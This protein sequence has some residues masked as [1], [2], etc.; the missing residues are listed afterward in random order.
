MA[1]FQ[2]LIKNFDRIRNYMRDFYIYGFKVRNDYKYKSSRTYD[3]ERRRIESWIGDYIIWKHDARGKSVSI[4][5][6]SK[7]VCSNPL[8]AIWKSKSFTDNDIILHFLLL[9]ILQKHTYSADEITDKLSKDYGIIFDM[10]TVR[11]KLNEYVKSGILFSEKSGKK[12]L[13]SLKEQTL[14]NLYCF[15]DIL[16]SI[17]YYQETMP[18]GFVGNTILDQM[19]VRNTIFRFKHYFMVHTLEDIILLQILKCIKEKRFISFENFSRKSNRTMQ[20]YGVPMKIQVSTQT[21]R[22]Y[23]TLYY[24]KNRRFGNARLDY[25][26]SVQSGNIV[27]YY[28]ELIIKYENAIKKCWGVSFY[29]RPEWLYVK[30]YIDEET[31]TYIIERIKKEGRGGE[32]LHIEKNTYL[33]SVESYDSN[34]IMSW[35]KTFTGRILSVECTNQEIADKF[36]HDMDILYDMYCKNKERKN[37]HY[38]N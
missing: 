6:D 28:D 2:E 9:D 23:I 3:N 37:I 31:E 5:I 15:S 35:V 29:S 32:L 1:A 10:Q 20:L 4:S 11:H 19:Q 21:G 25:I 13:Y 38:Y 14:L 30:L 22:R 34:E 33:Y 24:P 7:K 16:E 12:L 26:Q 18:F 8:Y 17:K 36:Y 27:P